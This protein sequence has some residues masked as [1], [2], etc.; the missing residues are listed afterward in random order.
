MSDFQSKIDEAFE[1]ASGELAKLNEKLN[2]VADL[3]QELDKL[4]TNLNLSS[5][6]L[7]KLTKDHAAYLQK[8]DEL[9]TVFKQ[10]ADN[11]SDIKPKQIEQ[12][13]SKVEK[14]TKELGEQILNVEK[15]V[16]SSIEKLKTFVF[17]IIL[18]FNIFYNVFCIIF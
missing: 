18:L 7:R 4:S 15:S 16:H 12:K 17:F 8:A 2:K 13:L 14:Q 3:E 10:I 9:N 1:K 11:L 5:S 6:G